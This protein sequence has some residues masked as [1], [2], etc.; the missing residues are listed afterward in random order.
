ML[1]EVFEWYDKALAISERSN[2]R[3]NPVR[4]SKVPILVVAL[5]SA[6][7][8]GVLV[9]TSWI[10]VKHTAGG[11]APVALPITSYPVG[12]PSPNAVSKFGPPGAKA[13]EGYELTYVDDFSHQG[14]PKGW[15][16]F[17]GVPGGDPGAHFGL[18]HVTVSDR[19]LVLSTYRDKAYGDRWVTG[20]MCQCGLASVYGAYFVRS[21]VTAGGPN[22]VELLWPANNQWPPEIDFNESSSTHG[23]TATVHW[24]EAD[25]ILQSHV[26]D[27]NLT[28]WHTWGVIWTSKEIVYILD[29]RAWGIVTDPDAIPHVKMTLD[30]EQRTECS[31]H[32]QCP[33]EPVQMDVAW[34]AEYHAS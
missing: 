21:R 11:G 26:P 25:F 23:T 4:A 27:V 7:V 29:G 34:I 32:R 22:E 33:K 6:L 28:K 16:L 3:H 19:Q 2:P 17:H 31:I 14:I 1:F 5:V 30:L 20:G 15:E 10:N 12:T 24:G 8:F 13:L 18:A 9:V